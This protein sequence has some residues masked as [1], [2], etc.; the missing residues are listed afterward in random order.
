MPHNLIITSTSANS[1][2]GA[3]ISGTQIVEQMVISPDSFVIGQSNNSK[4]N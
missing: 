4:S 1:S 2:T 3:Q